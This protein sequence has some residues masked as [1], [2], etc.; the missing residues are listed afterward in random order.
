MDR[1]FM[2]T[3]YHTHTPHCG[4]AVGKDAAEYAKAAFEQKMD[5]LGFSDH[6]AFP[7]TDYGC[8]MPYEEM[9]IYFR[10]VEEL[11]KEYQPKGMEIYKGLE[12]EFLP[13]YLNIEGIPGKNYYE[14]LLNDRKVDYLLCGEHFFIDASGVIDNIYN[15]K[16][17]KQVIAYAKSCRAAME[18]GYFKMLA[19]PDLFG[20]NAFPWCE[21]YDRACDIILEGAVKSGTILEYNANGFRRGI[22]SFPDGDRLMYPLT[23]FW[24]KVK[25][26]EIKVIIGSDSH[27]PTEIWDF[28]IEK[29][30]KYLASVGITPIDTIG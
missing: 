18:T 7:D 27:N 6:A 15:I 16:D 30:K 23:K 19:H 22:H 17:T 12:I 11:K 28:A 24:D 21:D 29:A 9:G 25:G 2:R 3:N 8:R 14:Y 5:I 26:T 10:E 20:V 1:G 4:H 13:K